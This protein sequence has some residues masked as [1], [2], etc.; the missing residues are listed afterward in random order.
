[1]FKTMEKER[2]YEYLQINHGQKIIL[3]AYEVPF[4]KPKAEY[5]DLG[6][7]MSVSEKFNSKWPAIIFSKACLVDG[8]VLIQ[9]IAADNTLTQAAKKINEISSITLHIVDGLSLTK[10]IITLVK[11]SGI[12]DDNPLIIYPGN[13]SQS[14]RR[15]LISVDKQFASNSLN[16]STQRTMIRNGEFDLTV[17]YSP[18]PQNIDTK[19]VLIVDDVVASGQT[20]QAI[21]SE[22]KA[23][24][25]N[26]KCVL[27]TW[28][29]L[30]PTKPTN[31]ASASGIDGI[32]QTLASIV[33]KGNLTS[34]P[35]INSLSCFV[36]NEKEYEQV[37]NEFIC[38]YMNDVEQFQTIL[39]QVSN[40]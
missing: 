8:A 19:T 40:R 21:S 1:M 26:V 29:F 38:K 24:F 32:E 17:D 16:L 39:K 31:K 7:N 12:L 22:I 33:L 30:L 6:E 2:L 11:R 35:P 27:A 36:R 14:V 13:G 15:H 20:A 37:K 28:L 25:P 18:L 10:D 34:R 3:D 5:S 23:R 9:D 4:L